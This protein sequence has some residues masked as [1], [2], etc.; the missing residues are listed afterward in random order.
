MLPR[1][2][3][4]LISPALASA[5]DTTANRTDLSATEVIDQT[6]LIGTQTAFNMW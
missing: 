3:I 5:N 2:P 6:G 4:G 1:T